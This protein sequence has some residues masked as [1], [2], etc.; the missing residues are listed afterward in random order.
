MQHFLATNEYERIGVLAWHAGNV[1]RMINKHD[2][3]P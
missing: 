3:L 2:N 1:D